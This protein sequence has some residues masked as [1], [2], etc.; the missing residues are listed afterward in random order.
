MIKI[1]PLKIVA[2]ILGGLFLPFSLLAADKLLSVPYTTQIPNGR[3]VNPWSNAC[4]ESSVI[5]VDNYYDGGDTKITPKKAMNLIQPLF[6]YENKNFGENYD[7]NAFRTLRMINDN[8]GFTGVIKIDP[9]LQE[10]KDHLKE[11]LPILTL[12]YGF[13]LPNKNLH[14][15]RAGSSYHMMVLNGFDNSDETFITN[16]PGDIITG[17]NHRYKYKDFLKSLGDFN[18]L[19]KKVDRNRPTVIL[20]Y[21]KLAK[22]TDDDKIY[23]LQNGKKYLISS[24]DVF[25][26]NGWSWNQI[27][28]VPSSTLNECSL[29]GELNI[30]QSKPEKSKLVKTKDNADIFLIQDGEKILLGNKNSLKQY[31]YQKE[32]VAEVD[33]DWL[34]KFS[35]GKLVS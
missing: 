6:N 25:K 2:V 14:F 31:G 30:Y 16:D 3:W 20:T 32:N 18:H 21:P 11:G 10:I 5:M 4:E 9:T 13:V 29:A 23:Y 12:H 28:T 19:T 24:V 27:K 33:T 17:Y 26:L 7:S 8:T 35:D 34:N 22:A 15:L 1:N